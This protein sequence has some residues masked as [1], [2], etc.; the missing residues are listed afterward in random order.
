MA[1]LRSSFARHIV[2]R[3]IGVFSFFPDRS[4]MAVTVRRRAYHPE[5]VT[6][7]ADVADS[8]V[9][10]Q[11][12]DIHMGDSLLGAILNAPA[13]LTGHDPQIC[14]K[15]VHMI[16]D[17][18][19]KYRIGEEELKWIISGDLTRV[20]ATA[21]FG[22]ARDFMQSAPQLD[23]HRWAIRPALGVHPDRYVDVPGNHDHFDGW[24]GGGG[25]AVR[26]F[27]KWARGG[28]RAWNGNLFPNFFR[29]C[30]W[31]SPAGP[32]MSL[33]GTIQLDLFGVD[34]DSGLA[35]QDANRFAH[36]KIS[37]VE[38]QLLEDYLLAS[39]DEPAKK[40]VTRVRAIVCHHAF[41][42][43][44]QDGLVKARPLEAVSRLRLLELAAQY[45]VAAVLT[46]HTHLP[47]FRKLDVPFPEDEVTKIGAVYEIRCPTTLQGTPSLAAGT[48][49]RKG[50]W[51][52][53][54]VRRNAGAVVEWEPRLYLYKSGDMR[55]QD[56]R[57]LEFFPT[58]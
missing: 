24:N 56:V 3:P 21:E 53:R 15:L 9:F 46:G 13:G 28:P 14:R 10:A 22:V 20:G 18:V 58:P 31:V 6:Q 30:P 57:D 19:A 25:G 26:A 37:D 47:R 49:Q 55:P 39:R 54:L 51:M 36:G 1:S 45:R 41:T 23:R 48:T 2:V 4:C 12:S 32:W 33:A 52:H 43:R 16:R 5:D 42:R 35:G 29:P 27:L 11:I 50:F 8:L 7:I 34:S 17:I 44:P 40:G 38:F